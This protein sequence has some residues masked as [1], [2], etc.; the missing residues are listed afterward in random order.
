MPTMI[1]WRK[2]TLP[3]WLLSATGCF[4]LSDAASLCTPFPHFDTHDHAVCPIDAAEPI[5]ASKSLHLGWVKG[6]GD[7]CH[8]FGR[9]QI[10]TF[11]HP[12]FN[13]GLGIALITTDA[14][15]EDISSWLPMQPPD[16]MAAGLAAVPPYEAKEIPGKGIGLV[17]NRKIRRGELIM[18]RT[19][20]VMVDGTAFEDL[21]TSHLTRVLARAIR[22]LPRDHQFE[23]LQLTTHDDATTYED[24]VYKIFAKNNFRTKFNKGKD[25]HSTFTQGLISLRHV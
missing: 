22:S 6:D 13:R 1:R 17:A 11:T 10:C 18:A 19:P 2:A 9:D 16:A 8:G 7:A 21:S 24:R 5:W 15:L 3:L 20:A 4:C 14:I 12:K 25:F 23:Y